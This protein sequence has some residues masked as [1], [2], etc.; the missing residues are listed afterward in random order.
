ML[1]MNDA[2]YEPLTEEAVA[3]QL[4]HTRLLIRDRDEHP[5]SE[6]GDAE[7]TKFQDL[8]RTLVHRAVQ[9]QPH[10]LRLEPA[11]PWGRRIRPRASSV[12]LTH[13]G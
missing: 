6:A 8:E 12:Y 13:A 3:T 2:G 10:A 4:I 11:A 9:P 7:L 1:G 5:P